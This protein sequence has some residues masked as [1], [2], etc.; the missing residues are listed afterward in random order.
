MYLFVFVHKDAFRRLKALSL[1]F[2]KSHAVLISLKLEQIMP[3]MINLCLWE[4]LL[5]S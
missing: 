3:I 5:Y 1:T 4:Y 2:F